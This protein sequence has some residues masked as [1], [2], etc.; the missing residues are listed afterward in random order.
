MASSRKHSDGR[1]HGHGHSVGGWRFQPQISGGYYF[2][3]FGLH[4]NVGF[5]L[6]D[7]DDTNNELRHR[8]ALTIDVI[9]RATFVTEL[10]GRVILDDDRLDIR[11]TP[12]NPKD[13][14]S[15]PL[16]F[17][18]GIKYNIFTTPFIQPDAQS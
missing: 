16:D 12:F 9:E 17:N 1:L 14:D 15:H 5:D 2:G 8:T 4:A 7:T 6:G 13:A 11:S 10:L 3:R 18:V